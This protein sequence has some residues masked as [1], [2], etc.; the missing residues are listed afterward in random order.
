MTIDVAL[1]RQLAAQPNT[2]L[3][4]YGPVVLLKPTTVAELLDAYEERDHLRALLE[5]ASTFVIIAPWST[6]RVD[7]LADIDAALGGRECA[8]DEI[9]RLR[10]ALRQVTRRRTAWLSIGAI[11][12]VAEIR[13]EQEL[14]EEWVRLI[15]AL[16]GRE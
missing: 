12:N 9:L 14:F 8:I 2:S 6:E 5:R 16:E 4:A 7:L 13:V 11:N 10:A 3:V 1:L 15:P